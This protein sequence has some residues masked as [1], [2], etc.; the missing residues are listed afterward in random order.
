MIRQGRCKIFRAPQELETMLTRRGYLCRRGHSTL[1]LSPRPTDLQ[2]LPTAQSSDWTVML[3]SCIIFCLDFTGRRKMLNK[4]H[5]PFGELSASLPS[6]RHSEP[7]QRCL[8]FFGS[9]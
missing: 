6:G 2:V 4:T 1:T 9:S 8:S 5:A 3:A 7:S